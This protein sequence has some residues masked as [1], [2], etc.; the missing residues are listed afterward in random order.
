MQADVENEEEENVLSGLPPVREN[1]W[2]GTTSYHVLQTE[3]PSDPH[4]H[5]VHPA[6][7]PTAP[8]MEI[9]VP[10]HVAVSPALAKLMR[11]VVPEGGKGQGFDD[12]FVVSEPVEVEDHT[13]LPVKVQYDLD[14]KPRSATCQA[15]SDDDSFHDSEESFCLLKDP[16]ADGSSREGETPENTVVEDGR[17]TTRQLLHEVDTHL[18]HL[19]HRLDMLSNAQEGQRSQGQKPKYIRAPRLTCSSSMIQEG[20]DGV[21]EIRDF[22]AAVKAVTKAQPR[23]RARTM[24]KDRSRHPTLDPID[25]LNQQILEKIDA[26]DIVPL[27][28]SGVSAP[29]VPRQVGGAQTAYIKRNTAPFRKIGRLREKSLPA[30]AGRPGLGGGDMCGCKVISYGAGGRAGTQL[31]Q[32]I[33]YTTGLKP[34]DKAMQNCVRRRSGPLSQGRVLSVPTA[35]RKVSV[36]DALIR[37]KPATFEPPVRIYEPS[38]HPDDPVSSTY[39]TT[40]QILAQLRADEAHLITLGRDIEGFRTG[41][42]L[43]CAIDLEASDALEQTTALLEEK[44]RQL[45]ELLEY[46]RQLGIIESDG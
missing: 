32:D 20:V 11:N 41:E 34:I 7:N 36:P 16:L 40:A 21:V 22:E 30:T 27:V 15:G 10:S 25:L 4:G 13:G 38:F 24:R 43:D 45:Q 44:R 17:V 31:D 8:F 37:E 29:P 1:W 5:R 6:L 35:R 28:Q 42:L 18:A 19:R 9:P 23:L 39:A 14:L 12:L 33:N 2:Y 46:R 3:P 26:R